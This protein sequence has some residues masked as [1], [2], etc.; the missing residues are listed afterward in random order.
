MEFSPLKRTP[1][2]TNEVDGAVLARIYEDSGVVATIDSNISAVDTSVAITVVSGTMPATGFYKINDEWGEYTYTGVTVTFTVR[3]RLSTNA[4]SHTSG[5]TIQFSPT[6]ETA[7]PHYQYNVSRDE[8]DPMK[9]FTQYD[10]LYVQ[11]DDVE[12]YATKNG[13]KF[14]LILSDERKLDYI[15][16]ASNKIHEFHNM[17]LLWKHQKLQLSCI[18]QA[19]HFAKFAPSADIG[20]HAEN[21]GSFNDGVTSAQGGVETWNSFAL[22]TLRSVMKDSGILV[23][24]RWERG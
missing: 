4:A 12:Q 21:T 17:G 1:K 22:Y 16:R 11:P 7:Q 24:D 18:L 5:D 10:T 14:W 19:I 13:K 15:E 2:V 6:A 23:G 9:T 3:G 20:I 8:N